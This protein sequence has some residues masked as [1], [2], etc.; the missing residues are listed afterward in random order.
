MARSAKGD[1]GNAL[2][3]SPLEAIPDELPGRWWVAHTKPRQEK[4]LALDLRAL[5]VFHYLP[6]YQHVTRSRNTGRLSQSILPVFTGY[7]FFNATEE[8]RELALKT[9]RIVNTLAVAAQSELVGQLRGIQQ[10]IVAG[11]EFEQS[12]KIQVGSWARVVAGPLAGLEG[13]VCRQLARLRLALNVQM[14]GQAVMVE[15]AQD[16]L[17]EI[18][19]PSYAPS[20]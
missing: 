18:D 5:D 6:L 12:R 11:S 1:W 4:A 10:V 17:E 16:A 15:V 2:N 3:T 13:V 8:R 19:G 14:L 9:N 7:L 20:G